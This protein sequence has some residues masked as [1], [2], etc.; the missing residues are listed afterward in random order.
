MAELKAGQYDAAADPQWLRNRQMVAAI[1]EAARRE[2]KKRAAE[3]AEELELSSQPRAKLSK[4]DML[5]QYPSIPLSEY[6][7][8]GDH[9]AINTDFPG[10]RAIHKDPWIFLVPDLLTRDEC[11]KLMAKAGPH[12]QPSW[13]SNDHRTSTEC[14]IARKETQGIQGRYS[15]LLN[16]PVE[17]MEAA[18]VSRYRKGQYSRTT[19]TRSPALTFWRTVSRRCSCTSTTVDAAGRHAFSRCHRRAP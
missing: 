19:S 11:E 7:P 12:F 1:A 8:D 9:L 4:D 16:M 3:E 6:A 2:N 14:R 17:N 5:A 15:K 18:K 10:L 13:Y